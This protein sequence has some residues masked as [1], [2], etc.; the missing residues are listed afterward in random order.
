MVAFKGTDGPM[1]CKRAR[2]SE[3]IETEENELFSLRLLW[4]GI[5]IFMDNGTGSSDKC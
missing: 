1:D 4:T 3:A 5:F 2:D